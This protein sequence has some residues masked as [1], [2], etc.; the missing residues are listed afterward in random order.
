MHQFNVLQPDVVVS[1]RERQRLDAG[2]SVVRV[3]AGRDG[4][5]SLTAV[6]RINVTP[7][8]MLAWTS[9]VETLQKGKYVPEIGRFSSPPRID[10]LKGLSIDAGDLS[11]LARCLPGDCGVKLSAGEMAAFTGHREHAVLERR[12]REMFVHRAASY[13][14]LGDACLMPYEDHE[15]P[16]AP[17]RLFDALVQR[18]PFF[19]RT[20]REY[21]DYLRTY[22]VATNGL[23]PRSFLYWSK[24]T[25][26][27]KPIVS[28]THFS[29][30][31]F[32]R[33]DLPEVVVV[34]K[35]VYA[36]HYKNASVTVTALVREGN[37]RYL[38]YLNRSHVDAFS[39]TFGGMVRRIV[40]RRVKSEAPGVLDGLR[41]RFE[42]T[43]P[44]A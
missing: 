9:S 20:L 33:P 29:A 15:E 26:G 17:T 6:V 31:R 7:E 27:M 25:L 39:G 35:Q 14:A 21:A 38:V 36:S 22:P 34:A 16:I 42:T 37:A 18:L 43:D 28:I 4:F 19:P 1:E 8:R 32:D 41:R 44:P 24:E 23:T 2:Q 11:D 12:F 10:D 13:Q 30:A 40:E 3:A 5:L